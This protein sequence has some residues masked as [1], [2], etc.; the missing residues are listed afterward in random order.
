MERDAT[1][2]THVSRLSCINATRSLY[3][4]VAGSVLNHLP[5]VEAWKWLSR[6]YWY[7]SLLESSHHHHNQHS[8]VPPRHALKVFSA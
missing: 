5:Q 3:G 4:F 6:R 8:G 7:K 1:F 2:N